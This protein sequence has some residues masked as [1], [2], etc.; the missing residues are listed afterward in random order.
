[1]SSNKWENVGTPRKS[2]GSNLVIEFNVPRRS[3]VP[4]RKS[5]IIIPNCVN[6]NDLCFKYEKNTNGFY[7]AKSTNKSLP[8]NVPIKFHSN[9]LK[10]KIGSGD[11]GNVY[12]VNDDKVIKI[13][14]HDDY[15]NIFDEQVSK[16]FNKRY[17]NYFPKI[18]GIGTI[19]KKRFVLMEKFEESL[20][21]YLQR[22]TDYRRKKIIN[23]LQ[24]LL[25]RNDF[26]IQNLKSSHLYVKY[27]KLKIIDPGVLGNSLTKP[28]R[29]L[30][31]IERI[32]P[33][34]FKIK[35]KV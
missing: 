12:Q 15:G 6:R 14:S 34:R 23:Q 27:H 30:R 8:T 19:N 13:Y 7:I 18:Y 28:T 10:N 24:S 31:N 11:S 2:F 33:S 16:L 17:K 35:K 9:K 4:E 29:L 22:A 3:P 26:D 32:K 20:Y 25:K 1:M 5:S 21:R